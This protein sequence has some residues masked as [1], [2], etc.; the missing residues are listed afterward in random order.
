MG[1]SVVNNSPIIN[2]NS[3][4]NTKMLNSR[5]SVLLASLVA[6]AVAFLVV[7][8]QEENES[9]LTAGADSILLAPYDD[10]FDC[11][12]R[13][14]GYYGDTANNCQVFHICYP[15]ENAEGLVEETAKWSFIC[16]NQ[17]LWSQEFLVC[18]HESNVDCSL[19]ESFYNQVAYGEKLE[20]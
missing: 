4:N 20:E 6:F 18:D 1:I 8:A 16:P 14:Y 7:R 17:T 19:T 9:G 3:N 10:S 15:Y 2:S 5:V 11:T 13:Q 12:D